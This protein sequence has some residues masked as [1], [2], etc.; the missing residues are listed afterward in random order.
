MFRLMI[1]PSF[2]LFAT[3]IAAASICAPRAAAAGEPS[4]WI[5]VSPG[6][7]D[8]GSPSAEPGRD[9]D[10]AVHRVT[11]TRPF[12]M[13]RTEVTQGEWRALMTTAPSHFTACG[14]ECPAENVNWWEALAYCNA[15]STQEGLKACYVLTG[16]E[17]RKPG[18]DMEC[19]SASFE[20]LD[21]AGYRLPTE[22]EWEY[23]AR[24]GSPPLVKPGDPDAPWDRR[25]I[26]K[27]LN[28]VARSGAN[29]QITYGGAVCEG[30][31]DGGAYASCGP[32]PVASLAPNA[33]GFHDLRGNVWEWC[34]DWY[35]PYDPTAVTDPL[36]PATGSFRVFRGGAWR[37]E[38][39]NSR[40]ANRSGFARGFRAHSLGF[41]PVRTIQ[42]PAPVPSA[43]APEAKGP[44]HE[45]L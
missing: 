2:C 31:G 6:S 8:M 27:P 5:R 44:S 34:W 1:T 7:F 19:A 42:E 11:L 13:K 41:R 38:I 39:R 22:A 28:A 23:A 45:Q 30:G 15:Q 24:A 26:Y 29:S 40:A 4:A 32:H 17:D 25:E 37:V 14:D 9:E 10:E 20:G 43:P 16:C 33:W 12:L 36:G 35:A 18:E 3:L 21:C